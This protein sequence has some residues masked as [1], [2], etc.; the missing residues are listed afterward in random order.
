VSLLAIYFSAFSAK[1]TQIP[2]IDASDLCESCIDPNFYASH[3]S[4]CEEIETLLIN[5]TGDNRLDYLQ[6]SYLKGK[7][8]TETTYGD[9]IDSDPNKNW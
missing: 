4:V 6:C 7:T 2:A 3:A 1:A 9:K 8:I 5:L